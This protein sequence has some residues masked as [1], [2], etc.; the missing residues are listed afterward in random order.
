MM[1]PKRACMSRPGD[2]GQDIVLD[3]VNQ[4]LGT[5]RTENHSV[6]GS[7]VID[8]E[9]TQHRTGDVES[10]ISR[11]VGNFEGR[12][13]RTHRLMTTFQPNTT[14]SESELFV[15]LACSSAEDLDSVAM[16]PL[17]RRR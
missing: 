6:L 3:V 8:E 1:K 14:L 13:K 4:M 15:I 11:S 7:E 5:R 12:S 16:G 2:P 9:G 17:T 10:S